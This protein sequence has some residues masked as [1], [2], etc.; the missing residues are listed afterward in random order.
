RKV[1]AGPWQPC[2]L[3]ERLVAWYVRGPSG[4]GSPP[5]GRTAP[6]RPPLIATRTPQRRDFRL[7]ARWFGQVESPVR[8]QLVALAPG[9]VISVGA[10]DETHV[11]KG[12]LLFT[13]GGPQIESLLAVLQQDVST[14]RERAKLAKHML[15]LKRGSLAEKIATQEELLAAQDAL[16]G[17]QAELG[18]ATQELRRLQ[19][20]IQVRAPF[21]GTFSHRRVSLGQEVAKG[22]RLADLA[23]ISHLRVV[24]SLFP[25]P[26]AQLE[27]TQTMIDQRAGAPL[28]GT[29]VKVLSQR[30]PEGATAV[31]IEGTDLNHRLHPGETVSGNIVVA[32]HRHAL[33]VPQA[34]IIRDEHEQPYVFLERPDGYHRQPVQTGVVS[35]GWVEITSGVED[36][37][38]VVVQGAYELFYR[39]FS[40]IYRVAD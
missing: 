5:A 40:T 12:T 37:D 27:G 38:T 35:G 2:G 9:R 25:P 17:T 13:L 10:A 7:F 36:T 34:A 31:W 24:A 11:D 3:S 26:G 8:V 14:L 4:H 23:D 19:R 30:T 21:S 28:S 22:D 6:L 16:A 33:A 18:T 39:R 15:S 29:V 1:C 20:A 32:V